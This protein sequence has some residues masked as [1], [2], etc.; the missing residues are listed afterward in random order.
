M[1]T[2]RLS[3]LPVLR[4]IK[5]MYYGN[6]KEYD[7]ADGEGIRVTL[8]VSGCTNHCEGCFQKETWDFHFGQ[9]YTEETEKL[10]HEAEQRFDASRERIAERMD[11]LAAEFESTGSIR[12]GII[13]DQNELIGLL[14]DEAQATDQMKSLKEKIEADQERLEKR[15]AV[16]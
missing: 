16:F 9:E 2:G 7:V 3:C 4:F 14:Y 5:P 8:F 1:R 11:Q 10:R 15:K 6:I 12:D 13:K